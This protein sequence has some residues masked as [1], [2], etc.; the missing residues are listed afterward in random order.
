MFR[1]LIL[2]AAV[3]ASLAGCAATMDAAENMPPWPPCGG[4]DSCEVQDVRPSGEVYT[5]NVRWQA[6]GARLCGRARYHPLLIGPATITLAPDSGPS[7]WRHEVLHARIGAWHKGSGH[8][9]VGNGRC[10]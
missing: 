6:I 10:P 8:A 1:R 4:S 2:A 5:I 7:T 9:M 3:A